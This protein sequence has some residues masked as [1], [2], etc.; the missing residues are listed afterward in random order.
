MNEKSGISNKKGLDIIVFTYNI[1]RADQSSGERRF[2]A[3]LELLAGQHRV[4]L[5]VARFTKEYLSEEYQRYI[6]LL[7]SKGIRVLPVK[8][9][10]AREALRAKRYD[11]GFFEFYWI[12][13]ENIYDFWK[14]QPGAVTVVDSVDVHFA[15]EESQAR[16]GQIPWSKVKETLRRELGI[17]R[18]AD[19]TLAVSREDVSLLHDRH[20]IRNVCFVPN[21]VPT[22]PRKPGN[23]EKI[24]LFIGSFQ[25]PPNIDGM[26][27]FTS[28]IWPRV[29]DQEPGA[30]LRIIG[31]AP[32]DEIKAMGSIDGVKVIG[33]V[34]ET[35]PYL[36]TAAVS[37][38]PLRFGGGMKGKVNEALAH[39]LPVVASSFGAQGFAVTENKEMIVTDDPVEF[40]AA[41]VKLLR[42]PAEQERMGLAGQRLNEGYCSPEVV[43][44]G[45][46]DMIGLAVKIAKR[47]KVPSKMKAF[48]W[49]FAAKRRSIR[50][51]FRHYFGIDPSR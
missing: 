13:E 11:L 46:A 28:E 15:R 26:K 41:I 9:Q 49:E 5:C 23:R 31:T 24:V 8:Y 2:V 29:I 21:I 19:I 51:K 16:L 47:G 37:V 43:G 12:A 10:V 35:A 14:T 22:V 38:A 42:D 50:E 36:E 25:W 3:L 34:P 40:A 7:E 20:G 30:E 17:Y 4:D 32:T 1:P 48:Y 18:Q 6:P 44:E 45:L 27:W 33:Y 39:G